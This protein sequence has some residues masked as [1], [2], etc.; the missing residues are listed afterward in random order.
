MSPNT[1]EQQ[2]PI[3]KTPG[4]ATACAQGKTGRAARRQAEAMERQAARRSS[5]QDG[6]ARASASAR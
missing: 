1:P 5:K 6:R 3:E 2:P 4:F